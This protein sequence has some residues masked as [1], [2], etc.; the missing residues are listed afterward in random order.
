MAN[1]VISA[2]STASRRTL[3][4]MVSR[5]SARS[6]RTPIFSEMLTDS[7]PKGRNNIHF[8]PLGARDGGHGGTVEEQVH[9]LPIDPVRQLYQEAVVRSQIEQIAQ[10]APEALG[11]LQARESPPALAPDDEERDRKSTRLNS[12]HSSISYAVFCLKK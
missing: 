9:R 1:A 7:R 8:R 10:I 2:A 11:P 5:R 12:S 4:L 6:D 3:P